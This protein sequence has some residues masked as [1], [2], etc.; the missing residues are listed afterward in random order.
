MLHPPKRTINELS[1]EISIEIENLTHFKAFLTIAKKLGNR[2]LVIENLDP[3]KKSALIQEKNSEKL[4]SPQ[5]VCAE[6]NTDIRDESDCEKFLLSAL[7]NEP[8]LLMLVS[9]KTIQENS[10]EKVKAQLANYRPHYDIISVYTTDDK[11]VKWA[12]HDRR[13]DFI[14]IDTFNYKIVD[15]ALCSLIK[16]YN[17]SFEIRLSDIIDFTN[18]KSLSEAI[19][20]GKKIFKVILDEKVSFVLTANPKKPTH[21]RSGDQLR[22]LSSLCDV[23]YN[24]TRGSTNTIPLKIIAKNILKADEYYVIEGVREVKND[25]NTC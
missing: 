20:K 4:V 12:A 15:R 2:I 1:C 23:P 10:I 14:V 21:M 3:K 11:V 7:I 17:K 9:K 16:Q 25:D 13:V 22:A 5:I 19:R 6:S 8:T 24:K 18:P